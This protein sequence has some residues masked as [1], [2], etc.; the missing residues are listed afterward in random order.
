MSALAYR[1][2]DIFL[3]QRVAALK[4]L[5]HGHFEVDLVAFM[6][7]EQT[8]EFLEQYFELHSPHPVKVNTPTPLAGII[9]QW[10]GTLPKLRIYGTFAPC[11]AAEPQIEAITAY[12]TALAVCVDHP[13]TA[14][15]IRFEDDQEGLVLQA[16]RRP[17]GRGVAFELEERD[18]A[19]GKIQADFAALAH[20][21]S[22][23]GPLMV[24]IRHYLCGMGLLAMEDT[25]PGLIDAAYMQFYQGIEALTGTYVLEDAKKAIAALGLPNSAT[26][27]VICHQVFS[28]R[29]K[30]F[31][32]GNE[33]DFH[34]IADQGMA[35]AT[36]VARQVLVARWLCKTLL[37]AQSPSKVSLVRE[38]RIYGPEGSSEF[39]GQIADL[40]GTFW[41]NFGQS[42][43]KANCKIYD[44]TAV[45]APPY[46]FPVAP[47][48]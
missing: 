39:R 14:H 35:E 32:H 36:R 19:N 45:S 3:N 34:E 46:T 24:A 17:F 5:C 47:L 25:L 42:T 26:L 2:W 30:Y 13:L 31:G 11:Q 29:H 37:D 22:Q 20:T 41:V 6:M 27:Q 8:L 9:R 38:M 16:I 12:L 15:T 10:R 48:P 43:G 4:P 33:T 28:V 23:P 21:A 7:T 18:L 44:A 1:S 40:E